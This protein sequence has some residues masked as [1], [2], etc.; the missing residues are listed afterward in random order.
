MASDY[1]A[2]ALEKR[3]Q[4]IAQVGLLVKEGS[5]SNLVVVAGLVVKFKGLYIEVSKVSYLIFCKVY[6]TLTINFLIQI[7]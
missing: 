6:S 4:N 1:H 2:C 5:V 7:T 3:G